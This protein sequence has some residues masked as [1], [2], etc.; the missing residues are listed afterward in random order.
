MYYSVVKRLFVLPSYINNTNRRFVFSPIITSNYSHFSTD[1]NTQP[2]SPPNP[3]NH[4]LHPEIKASSSSSTT[5]EGAPSPH[6]ET[7]SSKEEQRQRVEYQDEQ[8]CVLRASLH[9]VVRLGWTE[10]AMIKGARDVG[11]SPS[12]IGSFP[13]KEA[14]LV[15]LLEIKES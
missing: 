10:T 8:A 5:E 12:I 14:A 6:Y 4:Q 15:E 1:S 2:L 7:H 3:N 9:H 11:L 13:R